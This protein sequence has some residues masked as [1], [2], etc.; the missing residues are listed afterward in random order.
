MSSEKIFPSGLI[1]KLPREGSPEWVKG[2][3]SIKVDEF[4]EFLDK[5]VNNGWVNLDFLKSK[6]GGKLYF[7][8]NDWKPDTKV[9][10]PSSPPTEAIPF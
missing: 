9:D 8:L 1:Y 6:E 5:N 4:K 3:L 7:A 10:S 2:S